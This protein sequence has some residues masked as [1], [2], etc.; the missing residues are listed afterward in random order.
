MLQRALSIVVGVPIFLAV[1]FW[2]GGW[3]FTALVVLLTLLAL[4][5]FYTGCR[6]AGAAPAAGAGYAA[7]L[8]FIASAVPLLDPARRP[9]AAPFFAGPRSITL[10]AVGLTLL[11]IL[12]LAVE[13]ARR[14]RA[15]LRNLAPTWLGVVYV[16]WLFPFLARLRW[17]GSGDLARI[18]A[19]AAGGPGAL[20]LEPGARTLLFLLLMNWSV[21]TLAFLVGSTWGRHKLAPS[22]SPNKTWEGAAGGLLGSI[23]VSAAAGAWLRFPLPWALAAGLLV[24]V[25]AQLG[26][27]CKSSIKREI[28]VKDFGAI[29]PGHGGILDRFDSLLF[30]APAVYFL[31]VL[32]P[33]GG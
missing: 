28:G 9:D 32:W 14:E 30:T 25:L 5:E 16:G 22:I 24:G 27:L 19:E 31:L 11:V 18:G 3:P 13:L 12:S 8:I 1:L 10:F 7:A 29:M 26:D 6:A 17:L 33:G 21:D 23:A 20:A 2:P 15:P 4:H